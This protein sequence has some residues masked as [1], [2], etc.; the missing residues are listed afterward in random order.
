MATVKTIAICT[1][2]H[3]GG[4]YSTYQRLRTS[5]R[6]RGWDVRCVY[7]ASEKRNWYGYHPSLVDEG[8][9]ELGDVNDDLMTTA[10]RFVRW[11]EEHGIDVVVPM[12]SKAGLSAVPHLPPTVQVVTRC[13][14]I[15]PHTYRIAAAQPERTA[16]FVA[17]SL[18]QKNDLVQNYAIASDRIR[19]I[20]HAIDVATFSAPRRESA[21]GSVRLGFVDRLDD[22]QK[23]IMALPT[24]ATRLDEAGIHWHLGIVGSGPDEDRLKQALAKPVKQGKVHFFGARPLAEMPIRFSKFDILVKPSRLE[25]FGISLIEAMSAGVIPVCSRI[26][27]VTDWIIN[28]GQDGRLVPIGDSIGM[29]DAVIAL[30]RDPGMLKRMRENARRTV[31]ERFNLEDFGSRWNDLFTRVVDDAVVWHDPLPWS[32]FQLA[33]PWNRPWK[34][35]VVMRSIPRWLKDWLRIQRERRRS[36]AT[37]GTAIPETQEVAP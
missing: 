31:E 2:P 24:I 5:L 1:A 8:C 19:L 9:V 27:G 3:T 4:I 34:E 29:A 35:R 36:L 11:V 13:F 25:G 15:T 21:D 33:A 30:C 37:A 32:Q 16:A 26:A 28:D 6:S 23:N 10:R 14:E 17:T 12:S 7:G 20:P 18:R 22:R